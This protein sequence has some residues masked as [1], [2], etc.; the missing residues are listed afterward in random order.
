MHIEKK[1]F[2]NIINTLM[3][4]KSKSKDTIKSRLDIALLCGQEHLH[5]NSDGQDPI[6]PYTW[7]R[8][9]EHVYWNL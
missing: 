9:Q 1:Y 3:S 7:T 5:V 2:D 8:I 4:V 6:S